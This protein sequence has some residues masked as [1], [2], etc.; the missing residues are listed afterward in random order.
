MPILTILI[1]LGIIVFLV[2]VHELGH[3]VTARWLKIGVLE[4]GIGF[5]P[6]L[7]SIVRKGIRYSLNLIPLGGFVKIKGEDGESAAEP[8]SFAGRPPRHRFLVLVAGVSMNVVAGWLILVVLFVAGAPVEVTDDIN[9]NYIVSSE[10]VVAEVLPDSPAEGAG[11]APGDKLIEADGLPVKNVQN[12]QDHVAGAEG[13]ETMVT[14]ERA[15]VRATVTLVPRIMEE[16]QA[17]RAIIGIAPIETGVVRFPV[18]RAVW[19]G[20]RATG[21]YLERIVRAFGDIFANVWRGRGV[22]ESLGGPVA[23]AVATGDA[24]GLGLPYIL[25]F[26]AILSFN[27]A[28]INILPFPAL[29]GGRIIFLLA[30]K[31]RGRQ[32]RAEVEAWFHQA[33][34]ALLILL[35]LFITYRDITRFGG[36]IWSALVG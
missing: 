27:L 12:F 29:D 24:V 36:R 17:G 5:P 28:I 10:V 20:T 35:I 18:H 26:T 14:Y 21:A 16:A 4:F 1:F 32:A 13:Q 34:F 3:F 23:I 30:E 8:D 31:L 22:G 2:L 15:G 19:E 9:P 25:I 11:L 33:G 7:L 6:R